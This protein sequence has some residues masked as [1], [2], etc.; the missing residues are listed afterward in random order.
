[1]GTGGVPA[2][3]DRFFFFLK[4]RT[5]QIVDVEIAAKS[6]GLSVFPESLSPLGAIRRARPLCTIYDTRGISTIAML[7]KVV[8]N[9]I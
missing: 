6:G 7:C 3:P 2:R 9:L 1:M 8:Q 4:W 5:C